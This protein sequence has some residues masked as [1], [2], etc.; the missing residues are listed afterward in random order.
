MHEQPRN[1]LQMLSAALTARRGAVMVRDPQVGFSQPGTRRAMESCWLSAWEQHNRHR[2][3]RV[4]PPALELA[5][6]VQPLPCYAVF[7][8][9]SAV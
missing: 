8:V 6:S 2:A 4:S 5:H 9:T 3:A 7:C 1:N